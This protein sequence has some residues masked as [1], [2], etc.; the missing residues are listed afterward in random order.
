MEDGAALLTDLYQ[1]TMAEAY[2]D[3]GMWDE[4]VFSLFVRRLPERRNFLLAAGLEDA[5]DFLEHARFGAEELEWLA[6]LGRFSNR[7]LGWLERFRFSGDVDAVPEGTP[8][9]AQ[10]PL[11]EVRA[12]IP[13][14]QLVE[15]FLI[16]Q[17]HLQ[18]LAASK[19]AR[20]VEA[21]AGR[22]VMEFGL[23]RIHGTDAGL[24]V[25]RAAYLA[26]VDAT[27][28][29]LAGKRYGIPV[30]GTMAHSYVQSHEDELA[31]FRAFTR[32]YPDA[33]LL[34][35][36]Y[37]TL[38]GV[39]H[40]I[41]LARERGEDFHVRALRLDSG[42]LLALS[43]A[44]REMLDEAGLTQVRL[45]ASGGLDEDAVARLVARGA[46]V[47]AFGVGTA[48]G[49]SAD[50]P[51]LDM[52]YKLVE[53]AGKARVK[54]SEGKVLLPGAKQVYRQE[55]DGVAL[56]DV[57]TR[58]GAVAPGRPL[59]RPVMRAGKRLPGAS[60]A[61]ADVRAF[62]KQE[63]SRLPPGVRALTPARPPYPVRLG[64]ELERARDT[65]VEAWSTAP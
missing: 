35:D 31:A 59:L 42:D 52:A 38:R 7:L 41:R 56:A 23:R 54:L 1:L 29:V 58:R 39:Q 19:A 63:V 47:D 25:A 20:V 30:S 32:V 61:L 62:A 43:R 46:P 24:K 16:N 22:P 26:G 28:N 48:M 2:L 5:L 4:A 51:S 12:P 27:S 14:A 6:S 49:V 36:T 11:L 37:D 33:T 18:T 60:P 53:Y 57:L 13:E 21:A 45:V 65:Q 50:A 34:V 55:E 17:V 64:T 10:E 15:T 8:V 3:E 40:V 44:A 9:F